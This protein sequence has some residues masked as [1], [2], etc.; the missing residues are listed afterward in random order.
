VELDD[1]GRPL[2]TGC[3]PATSP[4][5]NLLTVTRAVHC[6]AAAEIL[7]VPGSRALVEQGL[8]TLWDEHR[9]LQNGGYFAAVGRLGG[10]GDSTKM[11]YGHAHVVLAASA[12]LT[13][14]HA[15]AQDLLNDVLA[16]ID[17]RFWSERDGAAAHEDYDSAWNELEAYRGVNSNM[18]LCESLLAAAA[19]TGRSDLA[20]R[21]L[22]IVTRFVDHEARGHDWL[23]PEHFD[24]QWRPMLAHN[25]DRPDDPFRPYGATVGHSMEWSRLVLGAG[26]ATGELTEQ[27]LEMSEALFQRGVK[28]GWEEHWGGLFYTVDWDGTP[29]NRDRYWWPVAEGIQTSSY[30][31][32]LTG[33]PIYEDWYRRFWEFADEYFIDHARGGW[34]A[35]RDDTGARKNHPWYGK[36]DIYHSLQA[37]LLP[38]LPLASSLIGAVTEPR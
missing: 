30:L 6:Y 33:K 10:S 38:L 35:I 3:P 13:A 21:A 27:L 14:G 11:A 36:P 17:E 20:Q 2:P 9:D 15:L 16:V 26:L 32:R 1:D 24:L 37:C 28:V 19:A 5:Q 18:H 23:L 7:G 12:A 29:V 34:Y 4:R 8:R 22:R 25:R 31:L